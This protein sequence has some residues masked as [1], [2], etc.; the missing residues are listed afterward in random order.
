MI[1][2]RMVRPMQ[3]SGKDESPGTLGAPRPVF[4]PVCLGVDKVSGQTPLPVQGIWSKPLPCPLRP[5]E[6][7]GRAEQ[8]L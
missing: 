8:I 7:E 2:K 5:K 6:F 1:L 3:A 4:A